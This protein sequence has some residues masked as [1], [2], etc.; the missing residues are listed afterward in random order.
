MA[1]GG[2]LDNALVVNKLD[3]EN[4]GGLRK[5]DEFVRHKM[6][7]AVGDLTLAGLPIFGRFTSFCGGHKL[8][9]QVVEKLLS[10]KEF[11]RNRELKRSETHKLMGC[12]FN[13]AIH[14]LKA[15]S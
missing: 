8:N 10:R 5:P 4:K 13:T 3:L 14:H 2:S 12:K 1:L 9:T 11:F 7:D 15:V 6:L